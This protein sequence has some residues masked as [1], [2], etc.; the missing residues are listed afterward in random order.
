[1]RKYFNY[2]IPD[3][4]AI[5]SFILQIIGLV[6]G[7]IVTCKLMTNVAVLSNVHVSA[8]NKKDWEMLVSHGN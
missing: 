6:E 3:I 7:T 1:M 2:H 5:S 4:N 8:A